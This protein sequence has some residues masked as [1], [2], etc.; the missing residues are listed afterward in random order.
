MYRLEFL[1][2]SV[3]LVVID[4]LNFIGVSVPPPKA[5]ATLI[6]DADAVLTF[7]VS[8]QRLQP[9]SRVWHCECQL[10]RR[11]LYFFASEQQA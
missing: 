6:V 8:L 7:A 3:L 9:M 1:C 11:A 2:H 10:S 5:D 4:N